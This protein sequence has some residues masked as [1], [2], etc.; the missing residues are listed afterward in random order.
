MRHPPP[1]STCTERRVL[2][3]TTRTPAF[4]STARHARSDTTPERAACPLSTSRI[5]SCEVRVPSAAS[6][7]QTP[8]RPHIPAALFSRFSAHRASARP[9]ARRR[10]APQACL[11]LDSARVNASASRAP[12]T[13]ASASADDRR[14]R[15]PRSQRRDHPPLKHILTAPPVLHLRGV[16][17]QRAY[18]DATR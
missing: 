13:P 4:T 12:P 11:T 10:N 6:T 1:A 8:P 2:H 18:E 15:R 14:S 7:P 9:R 5:R 17:P 16:P 3:A